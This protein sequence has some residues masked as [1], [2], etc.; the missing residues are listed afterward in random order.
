LGGYI[1]EELVF[2][3]DN[4]TS[5]AASDLVTANEI[6]RDMVAKYGMADQQSLIVSD[7]FPADESNVIHNADIIIK[8]D[9]DVA[10]NIITK[11]R[12]KLNILA[13]ALLEQET[14]DYEQIVKLLNL[15][16]IKNTSS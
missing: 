16:P 2:G 15:P 1:A 9:Y 10:K 14:L 11:N 7:V 8:R 5:G 13:K 4:V 12:D 3:K 6:A